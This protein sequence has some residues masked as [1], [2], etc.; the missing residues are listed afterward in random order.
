MTFGKNRD[1]LKSKIPICLK[2]KIYNQ[3][4]PMVE[5]SLTEMG[6]ALRPLLSNMD[7]W[8]KKYVHHFKDK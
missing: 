1:I 4:P 2:R 3:V 5:Y 7:E 8:G 6:E